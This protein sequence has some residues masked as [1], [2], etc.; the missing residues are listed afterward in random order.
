METLLGTTHTMTL[1]VHTELKKK[2]KG[3][4]PSQLGRAWLHWWFSSQTIGSWSLSEYPG[5]H[6]NDTLEPVE[7]LLP[8]RRPL[9]GI[10]GSR[11]ESDSI[12]TPENN[13]ASRNVNTGR[14]GKRT[15]A[16][17]AI[18]I[19][20]PGSTEHV[21]IIT[22]PIWPSILLSYLM[23]KPA[24]ER[25]LSVVNNRKRTLD[26]EIRKWGA[27][28]PWYSPIRGEEAEGPSLISRVS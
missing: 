25:L 7:K 22:S 19:L 10:P 2:K 4:S 3:S 1:N 12:F 9:T 23:L 20:F 13:M 15:A 21:S 26:V 16:H 27:W 18:T 17:E 11:Q 8:W 14:E 5:S 24:A 6:V 28:V